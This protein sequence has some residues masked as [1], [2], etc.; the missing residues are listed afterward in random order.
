MGGRAARWQDKAMGFDE[1][2]P[3]PRKIVEPRRPD[4]KTNV[5]MVA[6]LGVF[7]ALSVAAIWWFARNAR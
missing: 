3:S 6:A 7:F 2:P 5:L 4:T 1:N